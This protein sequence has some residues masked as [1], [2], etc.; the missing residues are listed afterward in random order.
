MEGIAIHK[1]LLPISSQLVEEAT[2]LMHTLYTKHMCAQD[3]VTTNLFLSTRM[4]CNWLNW[5][6]AQMV[7]MMV[8]SDDEDCVIAPPHG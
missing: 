5:K 2:V 4:I 3:N 7:V 1:P 6:L 8:I